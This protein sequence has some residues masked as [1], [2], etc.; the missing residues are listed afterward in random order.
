MKIEI[1]AP[2]VQV[3]KVPRVEA[4]FWPWRR[5]AYFINR[6]VPENLLDD[7]IE[8][9]EIRAKKVDPSARHSA[10]FLSVEDVL[11]QLEKLPDVQRHE[12]GED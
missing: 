8:Q 5:K 4:E 7:W 2:I 10:L 9:G 1:E 3:V 11:A 12:V 6:G